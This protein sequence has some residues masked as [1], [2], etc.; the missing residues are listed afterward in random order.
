MRTADH[1]V[2]EVAE[3]LSH[4][5]LQQ[6]ETERVEREAFD[7]RNASLWEGIE[8]AIR[9]AEQR[10]AHE[11][12][13]LAR[14][15]KRQEQAEA[16]AKQAREAELRRIEAEQRAAEAEKAKAAAKERELAELA[17]KEGAHN[18][19]RGG[20]RIWPMA[21]REYAH[22][23]RTMRRIKD[24]VLPAVAGNPAWRKQ[25]FAAKRVITPKI[26]QLTNT[27]EDIARITQAI[28]GVLQEAKTVP[29]AAA[30]R[31]LYDWMLNHLAKCLIRQA[32]QEVA[33]RQ[34]TAYPLARTAMGLMLLG[35]GALG[36]VL[37]ARLVKKCP[38]VLGYIP[39][40]PADADERTYR[41]MLGFQL[42]VEETTHMYA[43]RMA[44]ICA[45]YFA[46]LQT[47]LASVAEL[48]GFA[49]HATLQDAAQAVP[50]ALR[51]AQLWTWQVRC[52]T[53][54]TARQPLT[55][56][57]WCTF[58]EV[59]GV[60]AQTRYGHQTDKLWHML[61]EHGV[62]AKALGPSDAASDNEAL[63]A[64]RVRLQLVLTSWRKTHSL[65]EH[66]SAGR[67]MD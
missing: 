2:Q 5:Q 45:L 47:S 14:A 4:F 29:D 62:Q 31:V 67:E 55:P 10:A 18:A 6:K 9:G 8:Q 59:A 52:T 48:T 34:E 58:L 1:A 44:G 25:C 23:Q 3:L 38:Y 19:M 17:K 20:E 33:A 66:A 65:A 36:D 60:V 27:R 11:A 54:P 40:R 13:Q 30:Q 24:D 43:S 51:P 28:A 16:E 7:R 56:A 32:E 57:L 41:K 63:R 22:W 37:M 39:E 26:G 35:H 53:P 12:E 61:F 42:D 64:A 21:A 49:P 46:C 50:E 15:R